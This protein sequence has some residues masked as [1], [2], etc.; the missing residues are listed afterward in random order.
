MQSGSTVVHIII[1]VYR[2]LEETRRCILSVLESPVRTPYR[3]VAIDD[4]SPEPE[5]SAWLAG[6]ADE[7]LIDLLRNESNRG[8][9][10]SV[11]RGMRHAGHYDVLLLNSDTVVANNWLDRLVRCAYSAKDIGTVT[12][13]SNNATICS[14]PFP[15]WNARLPGNL[16]LRELDQLFARVNAGHHVDIPTAVGF[17]MYIRQDCLSQVGFFDEENFGRGY[18]EEN[19][20]SQ[21]ARKL[22]WKNVACCDVFVFHA[23]SVSFGE[24]RVALSRQAEQRLRT[25]H[26]DYH[27]EVQAFIARD[28]LRKARQRVSE[29]RLEVEPASFIVQELHRETEV[30]QERLQQRAQEAQTYERQLAACSESFS[31]T[32][33]ALAEAQGLVR[34]R[35]QKLQQMEAELGKRIADLHAQL[36]AC[37]QALQATA[38]RLAIIEGSRIWRYS[39]RVLRLFKRT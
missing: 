12:P 24:E 30:L 14:Y 10:A 35:D 36:D 9:V 21:R 18:G 6:L 25:L 16:P 17:C 26:P 15:D 39:R 27:A 32:D 23:G 34:E 22:G 3:V 4:A 1:P 29:A 13:F 28:P 7:G 20:F 2:G 19:D 38:A 33:R 31:L 5:L 37:S 8:F 11:N